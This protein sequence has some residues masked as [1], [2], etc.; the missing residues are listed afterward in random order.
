MANRLIADHRCDECFSSSSQLRATV[1]QAY[2]GPVKFNKFNCDE[3]HSVVH[4]LDRQ[5]S[6]RCAETSD[7][8]PE[9][10]MSGWLID[11]PNGV[12]CGIDVCAGEIKN[13]LASWRR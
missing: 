2:R 8:R 10:G 4:C 6:T 9:Y 3:K 13:V 11:R 12:V 1:E 5:E 7:A